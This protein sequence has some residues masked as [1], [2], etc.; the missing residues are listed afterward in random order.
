[1]LDANFRLK[2]KERG[3]KS[4]PALGSGLAYYV[5]EEKY[6]E[7]LK[8]C[9]DQ[10]EASFFVFN[11]NQTHLVTRFRTYRLIIAIPAFMRSTMQTLEAETFTAQVGS[12][13]VN[14]DT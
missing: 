11:T 9:S 3:I 14:A 1:M 6:Q 10:T 7:H 4:D 12:V 2:S 5:E 13:H 8:T